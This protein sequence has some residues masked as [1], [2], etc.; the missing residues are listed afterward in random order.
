MVSVKRTNLEGVLLVQLD[1]FEDHRGYYIETYNKN[2]YEAVGIDIKFVQDD[3]SISTRGVLRGIH[4]DNE[5]WKL[6]T[7]LH[8]RIYLVVVDCDTESR[9]FSK[10]ES[11]I[12]TESNGLQVLAPPKHGIAHLVLSDKAIFHYKQSSYYNREK[13]FTYRWNDPVFGIEWPVEEPILSKRDEC[14]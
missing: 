6:I 7:C 11:F 14:R 5:T 12:L 2:A 13:Q 10:W 9:D 8:G 1:V 4:S 3:A